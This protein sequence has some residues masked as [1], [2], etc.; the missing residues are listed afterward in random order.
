MFFR[1]ETVRVPSFDDR[2]ENLK[3]LGI[4]I[5]KK[6]A[7]R[8]AAMRKGCAAIL[9]QEGD[10]AQIERSGVVIG[11]EIG[12]LTHG[13]YQM[14]FITPSGHREPALAEQLKE[15]HAFVEDLTEALGLTSLY[16]TSLGTTNQKH[17]YD[18]VKGR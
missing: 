7:S 17:L 9:V 2:L 14:F 4:G 6:G 3:P 15:L 8:A 18:R 10:N 1:R 12:E 16:N 13:G 5:A 11:Q